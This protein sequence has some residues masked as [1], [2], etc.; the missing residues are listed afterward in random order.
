MNP[1]KDNYRKSVK[2]CSNCYQ[3]NYIVLHA[4]GDYSCK[5]CNKKCEHPNLSVP[6]I[7]FKCQ[8]NECRWCLKMLD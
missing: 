8:T 5:K 3:K 4:M 1:Y 6:Q 7:C 2:Q